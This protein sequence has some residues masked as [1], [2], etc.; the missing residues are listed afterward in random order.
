MHLETLGEEALLVMEQTGSAPKSAS[1]CL[2][3]RNVLTLAR[4]TPEAIAV[5]DSML[6]PEVD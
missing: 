6:L 3:S 4:W 5:V 1:M 2:A